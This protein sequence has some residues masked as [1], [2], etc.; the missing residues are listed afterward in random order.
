[1]YYCNH[2]FVPFIFTHPIVAGSNIEIG[3]K[4][5][6]IMHVVYMVKPMNLASLSSLALSSLKGV[7]G[8]EDDEDTVVD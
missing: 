3:W 5:S 4:A 2:A 7:K 8:T 1:M 6:Q